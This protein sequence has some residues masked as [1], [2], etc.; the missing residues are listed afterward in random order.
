MKLNLRQNYHLKNIIQGFNIQ[1]NVV[2]ALIYRELKTR[3]SEVKF[4]V[5]GVFIQPIGVMAIFLIIFGLLRGRGSPNIPTGL[6]LTCG[7]VL[8]S[9]F[10]DIAIRSL[11]AM[12][13]N[14]ALFFYKPVK[15]VDTVIAR[16]I[17]ESC[18]YG[19]VFIVLVSSISLLRENFLLDNFVLLVFT[20]LLLSLTATGIG[21]TLMIAGHIYP[22][23]NQLVPFLLRPLWILSGVFYSLNNIP[24]NIRPFLSWNPILQAIELSRHYI[25]NDYFLNEAISIYYL[26]AVAFGTITF[27]LFIY[28]NN[29]RILL[30][31]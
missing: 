1:I 31:R 19:I 28:T 8:F 26:T 15:P 6:F 10:N 17:V 23:L 9:L 11:N 14:I 4:G 24:Q 25:S 13:A 22:I 2:R 7:I 27:G 20:F 3:V 29:E 16:S 21:L 5:V 12:K 30:S 18:L